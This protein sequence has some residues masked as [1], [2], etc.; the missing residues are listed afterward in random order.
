MPLRLSGVEAAGKLKAF[1]ATRNADTSGVAPVVQEIINAVRTRGDDALLEYTKKFD[2][3][4]ATLGN[5]RVR[6]EEVAAALSLTSPEVMKSLKLAASRIEAYSKK[7]LPDDLDYTDEL[8]IR[9]GH[10]WTAIDSVG[11]YVPGGLAFYPS[12]V[13]MNAV[14]AKVAGVARMA[15][16]VPAPEGEVHPVLLAAAHVAGISEIYKIGG[17]QAVA[18][19]AYGTNTIVPVDKIVGPGNAYVAEAKRQVFGTVGIDMIAGPSEILV[20]ADSSCKPDWIAADLLSQA[21]H[22]VLAQS[23]LITDDVQVAQAVEAEVLRQLEAL[24]RKDIAAKSWQDY[25][26]IITVENWQQGCQ[27]ANMIAAEH[28]E[29]AVENPQALAQHISHAGALFLG[30]TTPEALGDYIA[31][32]SHVLPTSGSARFSSGLSVFDFLKRSSIIGCPKE[33][34][35]NLCDKTVLLA[36]TEGLQAHAHSVQIRADKPRRHDQ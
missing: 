28:V 16:V 24:P 12:S 26:A 31:G 25:G 36:Q 8:G 3:F 18:A 33:A 6:P 35:N 34:L 15:M 20:L 32:P 21:E 4:Q 5:I 13:L 19:L 11:L 17:A 2:R 9:L 30:H 1:L 14:P 23:I 22:D 10:R 29:L 7:Q 27:L